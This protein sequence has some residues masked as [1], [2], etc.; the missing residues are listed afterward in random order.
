MYLAWCYLCQVEFY[1]LIKLVVMEKFRKVRVVD[2]FKLV[3]LIL[4]QWFLF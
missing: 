2:V 1:L 4:S 3:D